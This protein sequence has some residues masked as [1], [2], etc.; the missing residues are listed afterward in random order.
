MIAY[1]KHFLSIFIKFDA[2][3]S[4]LEVLLDQY[5]Y[6]NLKPLINLQINEKVENSLFKIIK[7]KN[8]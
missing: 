3:C 8:Q 4:F 1:L 2:N 7:L 5:F 6:K